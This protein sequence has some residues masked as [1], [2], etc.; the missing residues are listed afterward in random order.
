MARGKRTER[1]S[2]MVIVALAMTT[3][4]LFAALAIDVGFVWVSRTQSQNA[5][6]SAALAAGAAMIEKS[7]TNPMTVNLAA[8][9]AQGASYAGANATVGEAVSSKDGD[10][11]GG[12]TV[13][14]ADFEFG[15]WDLA[16]RT[17][18]TTVDLTKPS[19]V[20]GVRVTV[21]MDDD[22]N[23]KS[24]TFLARLLGRNGFEV[25]NT[26]TAYRGFQGE[27]PPGGFDLP[28]AVDSCDLST[29]GCGFDYCETVKLT[30]N[31][32]GLKWSQGTDPVTCLDFSPTQTQN[33]C[34]TAFDGYS[35]GVN[36]PAL[37]D[38]I[39]QGNAGD[40]H[41]GDPAYLDNGAKID[42]LKYLRNK[43]YGCQSNGKACGRPGSPTPAGVDRYG[44]NPVGTAPAIDSWVV[45][46][47]V[48][49]CQKGAQCSGGG[50]FKIQGGVCFEIR[51][52]LAPAGDYDDSSSV[53]KGRFLCPNSPDAQERALFDQYCR[54]PSEQQR[55]GGCDYGL[56][57][58]QVV[59]V[60]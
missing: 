23:K 59:I 58:D 56:R 47:P 35:S 11:S 7:G 10:R 52:I 39:D 1:G 43:F 54:D 49:E 37:Q 15:S 34:W 2:V 6:D 21:R 16:T 24:P 9:R 17:L 27:F 42:T 3:L 53:I 51:E 22:A 20:T 57:A 19:N 55:A 40:I 26:A 25:K 33:A 5:G 31:S 46:L 38:I 13:T 30:P 48:F 50:A 41:A 45:T 32:C 14:P 18:D 8:A 12:V 28:V 4:L 60:E 44:P 36:G 29:N